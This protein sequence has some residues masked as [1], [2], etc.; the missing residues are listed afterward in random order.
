[1]N[2]VFNFARNCFLLECACLCC[3]RK[4]IEEMRAETSEE[5][6]GGEDQSEGEDLVTSWK[7]ERDR[8]VNLVQERYSPP[9]LV[10]KGRRTRNGILR[11]TISLSCWNWNTQLWPVFTLVIFLKREIFMTLKQYISVINFI[12]ISNF[13]SITT[14]KNNY[15]IDKSLAWMPTAPTWK[16]ANFF[17][18]ENFFGKSISGNST[19]EYTSIHRSN[20]KILSFS[21]QKLLNGNRPQR[22]AWHGP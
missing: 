17:S 20:E 18:L 19:V 11:S 8:I 13:S 10:H 5:Q 22:W 4:K 7:E 14:V 2:E 6:P 15:W 9:H 21:F 16:Q 3:R 12:Y 1:M